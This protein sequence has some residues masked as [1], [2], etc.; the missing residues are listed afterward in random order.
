MTKE[1]DLINRYFAPLCSGPDEAPA[2]GLRDDTALLVDRSGDDLLI[3]TDTLVASV[4]FF[5]DDSPAS[6]AAKSL[7]VSVSDIIAKGGEPESYLLNLALPASV[8]ETW[9]LVFSKALERAQKHFGCQ[10]VGGDTVSTQGPLMVTITL[11]GKIARD[12]MVRRKGAGVG[13]LVFV[14]GP[15]GD[16]AL[17]LMVRNIELKQRGVNLTSKQSMFL[18]DH[19]LSP[20]PRLELAPLIV[21]YASAA[22]DVSDGLAGDFEKLCEASGVGGQI[23]S[24]LVPLSDATKSA[25]AQNPQLLKTILSGGD[26]YQ[27]LCCV[28]DVKADEFEGKAKG[29]T[30]IGEIVALE[31]GVSVRDDQDKP[32]DLSHGAFDHFSDKK[33]SEE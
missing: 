9:L 27:V 24:S 4:H 3:T 28:P 30:R 1:H 22:M 5:P 21:K 12:K 17:G 31:E 33:G 18:L 2:F 15:I 13:D 14:C 16:G 23:K 7:A 29:V 10:L 6:I 32:L 20:Q 26:D 19:Y 25:L 8:N 11:A